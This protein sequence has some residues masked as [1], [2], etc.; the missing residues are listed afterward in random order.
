MK[1]SFTGTIV[2]HARGSASELFMRAT[3]NECMRDVFGPTAT[4]TGW[5]GV[6]SQRVG[7]RGPLETWQRFTTVFP[8][9]GIPFLIE[10]LATFDG[11]D[12]H[13]ETIHGKVGSQTTAFSDIYDGTILT[14]WTIDSQSPRPWSKTWRKR[15][16]PRSA[17]ALAQKFAAHMKREYA[18]SQRIPTE[19]TDL[20]IHAVGSSY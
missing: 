19:R 10:Q 9:G 11:S 4:T 6:T 7:P 18:P 12:F 15:V 13:I 16:T 8:S 1:D 5:T 17:A 14:R 20:Y 2:V 3:T